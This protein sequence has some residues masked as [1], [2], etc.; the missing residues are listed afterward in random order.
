MIDAA[1]RK[2]ARDR[3]RYRTKYATD[4][5]WA[6]RE[7]DRKRI[8]N[9]TPDQIERKHERN[10][11]RIF[12][13]ASYMGTADSLEQAEMLTAH[14]AMRLFEFKEQQALD[15]AAWPEPESSTPLPDVGSSGRLRIVIRPV[16]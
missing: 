7:R 11:R 3:E 2:R 14:V 9:M 15:R 10:A 1:D 12:C 5:A 6:E 8:A 4:D 16:A 13:G